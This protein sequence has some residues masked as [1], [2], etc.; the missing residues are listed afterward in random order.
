MRICSHL[1]NKFLTEKF[2][3]CALICASKQTENYR[4]EENNLFFEKLCCFF[5]C[6]FQKS[7][8]ILQIF[9]RSVFRCK[10]LRPFVF[11]LFEVQSLV[12]VSYSPP[13]ENVLVQKLFLTRKGKKLCDIV[14]KS[15]KL[16]FHKIF[17]IGST[18]KVN[19][20]EFCVFILDLKCV[21][22]QH[23]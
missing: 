1:L 8:W 21:E 16:C 4:K 15:Q 17:N 5:I 20:R 3:F 23:Y 14:A 11:Y 6:I 22:L 2:I 12:L 10:V 9:Y 18:T 19:S 13:G 7:L